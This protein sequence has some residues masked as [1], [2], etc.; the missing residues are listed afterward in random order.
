MEKVSA[1]Q[2]F[3]L[4]RGLGRS[5]LRL[6]RLKRSA[7]SRYPVRTAEVQGTDSLF[8]AGWFGRKV[9]QDGLGLRG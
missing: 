2:I 6:S 1:E 8:L 5:R 3:Q 7:L 4:H 9:S